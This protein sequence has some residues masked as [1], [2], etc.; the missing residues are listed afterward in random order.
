MKTTELLLA[1]SLPLSAPAAPHGTALA[2]AENDLAAWGFLVLFGGMLLA[3][4]CLLIFYLLSLPLR[5][6][7]RTRFFLDLMELGLKDGRGLERTIIGIANSHEPA[8]GVHF[9]LLAAYLESGQSFPAAL[10][11]VPPLVPPQIAGMLGIG[12]KIGDLS[13]VLPACRALLSDAASKTRGAL[14]YLVVLIFVLTP[15]VPLVF[16]VMVVTVFPKFIEIMN[17]MGAIPA[18]VFVWVTQHG[19]LCVIPI[20]LAALGVYLAALVYVGGPRLVGWLG[21][22][23]GRDWLR[24]RVPW[25]RKRLDRDFSTMLALLLDAGVPEDQAITLAAE[26]TGNRWFRQKALILNEEVRRGVKLTE[27]VSRMDES[28]EFGWRFANAVQAGG[29]FQRA[30]SGWHDSLDARAF[31]Q[32]QAAAQALTSLLVLFNGLVV[33]LMAVAVFQSLIAIIQEGLLW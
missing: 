2:L 23:S 30:L 4:V 13:R 31:Q 33:G 32:E 17:E 5:R 22:E 7:E 18:P 14:N 25:Q 21:L 24:W 1:L 11:M 12:A 29:G 15:V 20:V 27:A 10:A 3:G 19:A 16:A 26:S 8:V 9:H 28:G 6:A